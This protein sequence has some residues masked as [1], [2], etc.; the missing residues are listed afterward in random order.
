MKTIYI[1]GNEIKNEIILKQ[2]NE[3]INNSLVPKLGIIRLGDDKATD[4]Y[5][6]HKIQTAKSIGVKIDLFH[7]LECTQVEVEKE[8][9]RMNDDVSITA[10]LIQL[11]LLENIDKYK[12]FNL[13]DPKKD[14]DGFS[15]FNKG[16]MDNL[17]TDLI[18][19]TAKAV[20]NVFNIYN[21]PLESQE[22]LIIGYSD[23]LGMPLM[24]YCLKNHAT[25]KVVHEKSIAW[26]EDLAKYD[27]IISAVGKEKLFSPKQ[28]KQGVVI[29]GVGVS[30]NQNNVT[31]GDFEHE[32][33]DGIA[34]LVTPTPNGIGPITVASL[35]ENIILT[36]KK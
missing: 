23:L 25:V 6:N 18:P 34:R 30:K 35:F 32:K 31:V 4:I 15:P 1:N 26:I 29:I 9:K 28:V 36:A 11:P 8:L 3:I 17:Q 5:I 24:K 7:R 12:L 14:V 33:F 27:I 22:I 21:I 2:K 16:L 20:I 10:I 19:A 13:I